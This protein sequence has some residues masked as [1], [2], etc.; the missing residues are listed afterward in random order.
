MKITLPLLRLPENRYEWHQLISG[1]FSG[2]E[3]EIVESD[4]NVDIILFWP[5]DI[6]YYI[7]PGLHNGLDWWK[8]GL[9]VDAI[10]FLV[11]QRS[12]YQL[13]L[14]DNWTLFA[15]SMWL[16]CRKSQGL[17]TE[18]VIILHIDDHRDCMSP[19]LFQQKNG[20]YLDPLTC[21]EVSMEAPQSIKA[22][23][24][25]GAIAVGSFMP[26]FFHQ[27]PGVEF[28]HLLPIHRIQT[29]HQ[30]GNIKS[31]FEPDNLLCITCDRPGMTFES[32]ETTG[33]YYH[34]TTDLAA[35]LDNI[36]SDVPVL[37]HVDMDYFNNRFDGDSDWHEHDVIH[38]PSSAQVLENVVKVFQEVLQKVPKRQLEDITVSLSPGFFP[39]EFWHDSISLI[40]R[41]FEEIYG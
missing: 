22:A 1:Y 30:P 32:N 37:L 35:F 11:E 24:Q 2:K 7:D 6:I 9:N 20:H 4:E 27:I 18:K 29:A 34:P 31:S 41:Q 39:A 13:S 12:K 10:P 28:R 33:H 36:P 16:D 15:W 5:Q 17:S 19:L 3:Y 8:K 25:S 21:N 14:N 26:I 23:I 38:D 40:D